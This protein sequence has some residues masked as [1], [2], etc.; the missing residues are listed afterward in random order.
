MTLDDLVRLRE[1][2]AEAG[3]ALGSSSSSKYLYVL[4]QAATLFQLAK[5]RKG[6]RVA[7]VLTPEINEKTRWGWMRAKHFMI[8]GATALVHEVDF[9][10]GR[11]G[12]GLHFDNETCM[13]RE[14]V[15]HSIDRPGLYYI[16]ESWLRTASAPAVTL[17]ETG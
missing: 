9:D 5:F 12:Y 7:L 8:E 16:G 6:D 11:F 15:T 1:R 14:G 13:D 2:W 17:P 10:K 3:K 4:E